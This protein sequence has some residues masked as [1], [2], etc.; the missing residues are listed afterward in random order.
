MLRFILLLLAS[1]FF[2]SC[3]QDRIVLKT[4]GE[5]PPKE[6][7]IKT[8]SKVTIPVK[9]KGYKHFSTMLITSQ[10]QFNTFV[11]EIK[12]QKDWSQ[13]ENFLD[14]LEAEK[15][16]FNNQ[17]LL[18]YRISKASNDDVLLVDKPKG[19]K[20]NITIKIGEESEK[21]DKTDVNYYAI[22]YKVSK[23][24]SKI[25]FKK[26][27]QKEVIKNSASE[28][29][30]KIPESCLEWFDGCNSCGRV[31]AEGIPVCTE[32]ACDTYKAFK[33]TKWKESST[34]P[35]PEHEPSHR[36]IE[37]ESLPRSPQLSNE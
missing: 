11:S 27:V 26:G 33:C 34:Q 29:K 18:I 23:S 4:I 36:D 24:V 8:I 21:T 14:S 5:K 9:E 30:S 12:S 16:N 13:K 15:T 6:V 1:L 20:T 35:K 28:S 32:K 31:G 17:N 22:A 37:L 7:N 10:K 19:D 25:T 3:S 2:I